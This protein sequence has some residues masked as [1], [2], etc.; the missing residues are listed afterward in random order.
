MECLHIVKEMLNQLHKVYNHLK[1]EGKSFSDHSLRLEHDIRSV[2]SKQEKNGF[3]LDQQKAMELRA[4]LEDQAEDIEKNAHK[5]FPPLQREEE[6]VPKVNNK[7]RGY[8]KGAPFTKVS[9]DEL[10]LASRKQT[11][12]RLMMLGWKPQ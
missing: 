11:A 4:K 2:V 9:Y 12:E 1:L 5:T 6:F 3:Y 10:N 8:V 7:T